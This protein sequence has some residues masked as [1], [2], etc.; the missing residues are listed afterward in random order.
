MVLGQLDNCLEDVKRLASL[1]RNTSL[2]FDR[3][4]LNALKLVFQ[5]ASDIYFN[6]DD[7]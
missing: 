4:C 7:D 3:D 6:D 1:E 5:E 2:A